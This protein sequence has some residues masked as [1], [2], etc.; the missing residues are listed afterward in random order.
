MTIAPH[1]RHRDD[2]LAST[3]PTFAPLVRTL[4]TFRASPSGRIIGTVIL[5]MLCYTTIG[6]PLAVIPGF[7]R[8]TLGYDAVVAGLAVSV[9]YLA[10]FVT[11]PFGGR[12]T[13]TRGPKPS[14]LLGLAGCIASGLLMLATGL[15]AHA[16]PESPGVAL[17]A[18]FASRLLLGLSES[19][20]GT[21]CIMWAIGQV[22]AGRTAQIISWNGIASY[23]GIAVGAPLGVVLSGH[24]RIGFAMLGLVPVGLGLLGLLIA[25]PKPGL[26][27]RPSV[28]I[29]FLAILGRVLPHGT[30]LA[31]SSI[32][33]GVIAAFIT[34]F[35]GAHGWSVRGLTG[36]ASA[37]SAFG[38][39]FIAGRLLFA[40]RIAR[41][42]GYPVA[43]V[44]LAVE[45]AGLLVLWLAPGSAVALFG[46]ILTGLGFALVFPALGVEAVK[47]VSADNRGAALGAYTVFLDISL[48]LS[49]P[50]LG[51][52]ANHAGYPML[53]LTAALFCA[54][55]LALTARLRSA[56]IP[57]SAARPG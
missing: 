23:G 32:G 50:M 7:V 37:L 49:G 8:D 43:M 34:L 26:V 4:R 53:F 56:A 24:G 51:L 12:L 1:H 22:G 11:R 54:A 20:V 2:A 25:V 47:R 19:L 30:A 31:C 16:W 10:T 40:N 17:A 14:V 21:G 38:L 29:P 33:F 45:A 39:S 9:Q 55:A 27:P 46:A 35:Y 52:I 15:L 48:G 28:R 13:D 6:L 5:T 36:A 57:A 41:H 18:L 44:S 42:G 3:L